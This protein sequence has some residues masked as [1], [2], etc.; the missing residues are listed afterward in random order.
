M[1]MTLLE[2]ARDVV[3]VEPWLWQKDQNNLGLSLF[4]AWLRSENMSVGGTGH[5]KEVFPLTVKINK[6]TSYR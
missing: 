1:S 4:L 2:G 5:C 3:S 6:T